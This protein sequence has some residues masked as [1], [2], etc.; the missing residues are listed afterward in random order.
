M[1]FGVLPTISIAH[2]LS[3]F[4]HLLLAP[5]FPLIKLEFSLSYAQLGLLMTVFFIVSGVGQALAGFLVD[6]V[7]PFP[8]LLA[9]I[10]SFILATA[11]LS[12][13]A[14]YP[15]LIVGSVFAGLG[16]AAF[17]PVDYSIMNS[18]IAPE[19]LG[20]AY[21]VHGICG[22]IGWALAP[23]FLLGIAGIS[24]WRIAIAGAG[25]LAAAVLVLVCT[26]RAELNVQ[27]SKPVPQ[28]DSKAIVPANANT[29]FLLLPAV[30]MS[31]AFFFA[32]AIALGGVQSFGAEAAGKLHEVSPKWIALCLSSY[33]IASAIGMLIGGRLVIDPNKA[34]QVI[35]LGFL[36]AAVIALIIAFAPV[37]GLAVPLLFGL[38]G[39]GSGLAGPSR[40][41]LV[42]R[43][44]PPGAT[45]R[46]YG[47][48][49]SGLD[50][51]MAI[52]PYFF[53]LM[54]DA[55]Q[56]LAVWICIALFQALLIGTAFTVGK[57]A[58]KGGTATAVKGSAKA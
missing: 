1:K 48:V 7:G 26:Q 22:N 28:N 37:S 29:S 39:F 17:H 18:R 11:F 4:F 36:S 16:N 45:G 2:G 12:T 57:Y 20:S 51:G 47:V 23:L 31:F 44:A 34:E 35:G 50:A 5:L 19:K 55:K 32:Y 33:M 38:M 42:R 56:P 6:K 53:G 40:D 3:H 10:S 46:V 24:N 43:A 30:W 8:V 58:P 13:A 27:A 41:L 49:Y 25:V 15:L 54:M 21:A 52:G 14:S 9:S